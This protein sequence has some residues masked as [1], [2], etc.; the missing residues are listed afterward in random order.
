MREH[1]LANPVA[2]AG[3][4]AAVSEGLLQMKRISNNFVGSARGSGTQEGHLGRGREGG[5][6]RY[7]GTFEWKC[8]EVNVVNEVWKVGG[9]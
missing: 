4:V 7:G 2:R 8:V 9:Y 5:I 1:V 3:D 6:G